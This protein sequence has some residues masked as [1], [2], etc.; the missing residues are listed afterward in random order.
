MKKVLVIAYYFP[1]IRTSGSMR[2]LGFCRYLEEYGWKP[3][4]LTSDLSSV[5]PPLDV[6]M[7]LIEQLPAAIQVDRVAHKTPQ[8]SL[9]H[10]REKFRALR[11]K[12]HLSQESRP[13]DEQTRT[14]RLPA[15]AGRYQKLRETVLEWLFSFPDAQCFWLR[16]AV[17][18]FSSIPPSEYPDVILAT[19]GPWTSFLVG[20]AL[21]QRFG[22]PFVADFRDPWINNPN[23]RQFSAALF[24][25]HKRLEKAICKAAATVIANTDELTAQFR[26]DYAELK[27]KFITITNGFDDAPCAPLESTRRYHLVSSASA[28]PV[29]LSH[30]GT[31]YGNRNPLPFLLALDSLFK[32][33][34]VNGDQLRIRLVGDWLVEDH[35]SNV[36]AQ[37]LE[38]NGL[39]RRYPSVP[40]SVCLEQMS[41]AQALLLLQ[42]AYPLQIPAKIFEY[43][44]AGRPII[45]IGGEGATASLVERHRAGKCCPNEVR[46]IKTLLWALVSGR[47]NIDPPS[48]L[49]GK[50][51]HYETLTRKLV[52]V[53]NDV[54]S[55]PASC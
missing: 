5:N 22:V 18:R 17:Q 49:L 45:V 16:P 34:L 53:L 28:P 54:S 35:Q 6:D 48:P 38:K 55:Q 31:I 19:G 1:P 40:H 14:I 13:I 41:L 43:I 26:R 36:L 29:E 44:A 52:N 42:P 9:L 37:Q 46:A 2:P 30:F 32:E 20:K 11:C 12:L 23:R 7:G 10:C 21:G 51:F 3:R 4:V 47:L 24:E 15:S 33:K 27:D 8:R 50:Q 25:R 39:L